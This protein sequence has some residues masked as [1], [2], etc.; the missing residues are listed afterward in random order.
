VDVNSNAFRVIRA[1]TEDHGKEPKRSISARI[2]GKA[3]AAARSARLKPEERAA[4][5]RRASV[6]RW[7]KNHG[8]NDQQIIFVES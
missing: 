6:A 8:R 1:L 5:A 3:G 4:I 2:A 7:S